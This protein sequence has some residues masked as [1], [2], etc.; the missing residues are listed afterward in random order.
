MQERRKST[1]MRSYLGAQIGFDRHSTMMNRLV[2]TSMD[3]L[4]RDISPGGAKVVL[5]DNAVVPDEFD[6]SITKRKT[7][8]RA[9]LVW[10][11]GDEF[12]VSF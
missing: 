3:G 6:L 4:V 7:I 2:R 5:K 1:R 8:V 11:R 12:G 10:R 9:K